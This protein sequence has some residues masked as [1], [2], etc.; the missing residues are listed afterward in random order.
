MPIDTNAHP[1][2]RNGSLGYFLETAATFSFIVF[3]YTYSQ[4]EQKVADASAAV[5]LIVM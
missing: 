4:T 3:I 5:L 2:V 1:T